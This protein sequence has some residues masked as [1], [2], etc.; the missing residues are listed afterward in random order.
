MLGVLCSVLSVSNGQ[1]SLNKVPVA[2]VGNNVGI[3]NDASLGS[4]AYDLS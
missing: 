1:W 3:C 4:F 2:Q